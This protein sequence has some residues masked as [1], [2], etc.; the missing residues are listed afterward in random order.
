MPACGGVEGLIRNFLEKIL[1]EDMF[2][3]GII[4]TQTQTQTQTHFVLCQPI[5]LTEECMGRDSDPD[6][7]SGSGS[8]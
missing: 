1:F 2:S 3:Y 6:S 8:V 5:G 7:D 4:Q